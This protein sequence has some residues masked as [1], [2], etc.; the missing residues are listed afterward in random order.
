MKRL[1]LLLATLGVMANKPKRIAIIGDSITE[2]DCPK[3]SEF[4]SWPMMMNAAKND[5]GERKYE[6]TNYGK[7]GTTTMKVA[8]IKEG[9]ERSYWN[10][11]AFTTVLK[12]DP[13]IVLI[14]MG[15]C[16]SKGHQWDQKLFSEEY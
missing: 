9:F 13:E 8:K 10:E 6:T 4:T 11:T 5:K 14:M 2:G 16:D 15:A 12:S 7:G 3:K 1:I